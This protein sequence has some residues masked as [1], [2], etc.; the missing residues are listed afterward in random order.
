[1]QP[2]Q[3]E[4]MRREAQALA[5]LAALRLDPLFLGFGVP[6]GDGRLVLVLPGL[7]ANDLYL[8]PLRGWLQRIGYR[9]VRSTIVLNVRCPN[10]M[11]EQVEAVLLERMRQHPGPVAIVGHSRGGMLAWSLA[12]RLQDQVSHVALLGSPVGAVVEMLRQDPAANP[13]SI[14]AASFVVDAGRRAMRLFDPDCAYPTC[15]CPYPEDLR[16]PL[17]PST[18]ILS[19]FSREDQVVPASASHVPNA[20]NL[21]VTGTHSGLVYNRA[22]YRALG[23]FL[24]TRSVAPTVRLRAVHRR[25]QH[26]TERA[27]QAGFAMLDIGN[28][29]GHC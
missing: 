24:A 6:R 15:G 4:V 16:R 1:M 19:V 3:A 26:S 11:R 7:F 21:E 13:S 22:A 28:F 29:H 18:R 14:P 27:G 20:R 23:E 8:Q 17:S 2:T 5:E 12:S 10:L 25:P 9:P